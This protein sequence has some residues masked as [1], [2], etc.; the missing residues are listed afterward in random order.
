MQ[1]WISGRSSRQHAPRTLAPCARNGLPESAMSTEKTLLKA[2]ALSKRGAYAEAR[3]LYQSVL[4]KFPDNKRALSGM[5]ALPSPREPTGLIKGLFDHYKAGRMAELVSAS[6][7]AIAAYPENLALLRLRA[8]G[9]AALGRFQAAIRTYDQIIALDPKDADALGNRGN[10][11]R[12]AG[13]DTA[14]RLSFQKVLALRPGDATALN[15]IGNICID[16]GEVDAAQ[17]C[18]ESALAS[19]P[20]YG[21]AMNNLGN[22]LKI[23][24]DAAGARDVLSRAI[25]TGG[26]TGETYWNF[27]SVTTFAPDTAE[28]GLMEQALHEGRLAQRERMLIGFALGKAHDDSGDVARAFRHLAKAN[29]L[30]KRRL[31]YLVQNDTERLAAQQAAFS[32]A[33]VDVDHD[34]AS[35]QTVSPRPIFI[36]GM[37]RSGTSLVEQ[38]LSAHAAVHGGGELPHLDAALSAL[39]WRST[40]DLAT[41]GSRIRAEYLGHLASIGGGLAHVTDKLP[42]NFRWVG[43]IL[44]L[45]PEAGI[46]HVVRDPRATCWS[47][48]KHYYSGDGNGFAYDLD[49][50]VTYYLAYRDLMRHWQRLFGDRIFRLDYERLTAEPEP[51]MRDLLGHLGLDWQEACLAP[52]DNRRAVYT[53]SATQV[54]RSVYADSSRDWARYADRIG[55]AFDPLP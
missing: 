54:R 48:F 8:A 11:Q 40:D 35:P 5:T 4:D 55:R 46:V 14:A 37:P 20:S 10:A 49:D 3:A 33:V 27:A 51:V 22:V 18:F 36:V 39:D 15:N 21:L 26:A 6:D 53:S 31:C 38:M 2:R 12:S 41:A 42:V 16:N 45:F 19:A 47:N 30:Q 13:Q 44:S 1:V 9:Q 52:Q 7:A 50:V 29:Q 23:K 32:D 28:I 25:A 43:A 17:A 24:G 34:A